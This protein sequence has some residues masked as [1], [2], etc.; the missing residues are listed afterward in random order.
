MSQFSDFITENGITTDELVA[1][2]KAIE[3]HSQ[4]DRDLRVARVAARREK[5][6]YED[7]NAA[8]P[9]G[10]GRGVS[11][12]I[13]QRAISG[14]PVSQTARKKLVRAVNQSLVSAKKDPVDSKTLFSD[15]FKAPGSGSDE[16]S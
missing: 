15:T 10:L 2:S 13:A 5:K 11:P 3:K 4:K 6:S 1:N 16:E 9:A 14:K 12:A 8:K 7:A